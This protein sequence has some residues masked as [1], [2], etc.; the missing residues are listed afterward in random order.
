MRPPM[1]A[2][3]LES[4]EIAPEVRQFWFQV[5]DVESFSFVPGQLCRS[6]GRSA[7]RPLRARTRWRRCRMVIGLSCA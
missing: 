5:E 2:T 4:R 3:L 7:G 1:T 6:R